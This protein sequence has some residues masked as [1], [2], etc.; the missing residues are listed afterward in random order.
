MPLDDALELVASNF[1]EY[2][3]ERVRREKSE[4]SFKMPDAEEAHLLGLLADNKYLKIEE[5]NR[6]IRYLS[7]RRDALIVKAGGVLPAKPSGATLFL[8]ILN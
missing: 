5:L 4:Y 3:A 8:R 7:D 1:E 6:V 2:N